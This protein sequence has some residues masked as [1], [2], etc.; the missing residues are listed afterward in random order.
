MYRVPSCS[1][2]QGQNSRASFSQALL[3]NNRVSQNQLSTRENPIVSDHFEA[4]SKVLVFVSV[5]RSLTSLLTMKRHLKSFPERLHC[6]FAVF[7]TLN[8]IVTNV[9]EVSPRDPEWV[10]R[11]DVGKPRSRSTFRPCSQLQK[12][13]GR[14][15][16][17]F[18]TSAVL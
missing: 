8:E 4:K 11:K 18:L 7:P 3:F 12:G 5:T 6:V 15:K 17:S 1:E 2:E 14:A 9:F 13:K 10:S 16:T